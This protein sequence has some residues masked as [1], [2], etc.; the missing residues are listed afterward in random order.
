MKSP[1]SAVE[2]GCYL[3]PEYRSCSSGV[4][5]RPAPLR[6]SKHPVIHHSVLGRIQWLSRVAGL[7][8]AWTATAADYS[9]DWS[10]NDGGGGTS[11]GG[12]YSVSGT[13]GQADAGVMSGGNFSLTG[14][15]WSVVAAVAVPAAPWLTAVYTETNTVAVS[16]PAPSTGWQLQATSDLSTVPIHW[17]EIPPPYPVVGTNCCV[18]DLSPVGNKFYRLH[19]P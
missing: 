4:V 17:T 5:D 3:Q 16:W 12:G 14:G 15:F 6:H 10:A 11:S 13:I 1:K 8:L 7:T 2:R 18:I 19:K 9:I